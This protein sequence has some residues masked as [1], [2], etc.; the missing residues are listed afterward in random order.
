M[1]KMLKKLLF[2]YL[3]LFSVMS[4]A[5]SW[6][7]VYDQYS[8][9]NSAI[10][11]L[12][13]GYLL[14][15]S[16]QIAL[17]L[18]IFALRLDE[19]GNILNS[20]VHFN[21]ENVFCRSAVRS[22]WDRNQYIVQYEKQNSFGYNYLFTDVNGNSLDEIPFAYISDNNGPVSVSN[23]K[24][25]HLYN[26]DGFIGNGLDYVPLDSGYRVDPYIVMKKLGH[27]PFSVTRDIKINLRE[28]IDASIL[29]DFRYT[30]WSNMM[31]PLT[32][33]LFPLKDGGF[34]VLLPKDIDTSSAVEYYYN[35]ARFDSTGNLKNIVIVADSGVTTLSH[36]IYEDITGNLFLTYNEGTDRAVVKMID[37]TGNV[38]TKIVT[39]QL[40]GAPYKTVVKRINSDLLLIYS[41]TENSNQKQRAFFKGVFSLSKNEYIS[42]KFTPIFTGLDGQYD[43]FISGTELIT[44]DAVVFIGVSKKKSTSDNALT[45]VKVD[46]NIY[47]QVIKGNVFSDYQNDCNRGTNERGLNLFTIK[48]KKD[49][50]TFFTT[51][52]SSGNYELEVDTGNIELNLYR[53]VS[54][55]FWS[56]AACTNPRLFSINPHDTITHNFAMY[57]K[58]ICPFLNVDIA[59]PFLRRCVENT[60]TVT[61]SNTGT[62]ASSNSYIDVTLDTFLHYQNSTI[63]AI[64]LGNNV[65]RFNIGSIDVDQTESFKITALLDCSA[66]IVSQTHCTE[67]HIYPDTICTASAYLGPI[68]VA[69]AKCYG[70]RVE[71]T[72]RNYGGNMVAPGKYQIIEDHVIR[73]SSSFL[74]NRGNSTTFSINTSNGATYRIIAEQNPNYPVEF[75]DK[76]VIAFSEGCRENFSESFTTGIVTSGP[77]FDGEAY[78]S[79]NCMQSI[80]S[81]DPN[82]KTG[83]PIGVGTSKLINQNTPIDYLIR[84]QNTGNDTAFKVIIEDTISSQLDIN[85]ISNLQSSHSFVFKRI[86]SALVRWTFNDIRLV[87]SLTNEPLSHGFI[88][89]RI[90]QKADLPL[91]TEIFNTALIYFDYNE[92]V[93]TNTSLHTIGKDFLRVDI[94]SVIINDNNKIKNIKILPNPF[95][96]SVQLILEGGILEDAVL[97]LTDIYGK[98]ISRYESGNNK[99]SILRN[100]MPSGMYL[101]VIKQYGTV[102][103]SGKLVAQ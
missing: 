56:V 49:S 72:L 101:Y 55:P 38:I 96:V 97:E 87:D 4:K 75:G 32:N 95:D 14:Y 92:P 35:L 62:I 42:Q 99:F 13:T 60:Y 43:F 3:I 16:N 22:V 30:E 67:A 85:S 78:R 27:F 19:D 93:I 36:R 31:F 33:I 77:L 25:L 86:D 83:Y 2:I 69:T 68:I 48:A 89:F 74:L 79:L 103:A 28:K 98:Q 102:I 90:Q 58:L 57:P 45:I 53:N 59:T 46:D 88:R 65:Y 37:S 24:F 9:A 100:E 61:Y 15:Q 41:L 82:D 23:Q 63:P 12:D 76:F 11:K 44:D 26:T 71:F 94:I 81:R 66:T 17:K 70:D 40:D 20:Q 29:R 51:S 52:D 34:S 84:F 10:I 54:K 6:E 5:N 39:P 1:V 18:N 47:P 21:S 50:K 7:R 73:A 91:G 80:A 64:Y 8:N